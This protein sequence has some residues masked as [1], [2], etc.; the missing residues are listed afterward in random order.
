[1]QKGQRKGWKLWESLFHAGVLGSSELPLLSLLLPPCHPK[2]SPMK[3]LCF[4]EQLFSVAC[5]P[6]MQLRM[7]GCA[8][9]GESELFDHNSGLPG[10]LTIR[11]PC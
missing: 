1:M 8:Q 4:S 5:A 7:Y 11:A 3:S 2:S 10:L 6:L 9:D